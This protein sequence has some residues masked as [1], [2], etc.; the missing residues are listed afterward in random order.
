MRSLS[1]VVALPIAL[2]ASGALAADEPVNGGMYSTYTAKSDSIG[3]DR[4]FDTSPADN[5]DEVVKQLTRAI[6]R[7]AR[8]RVRRIHPG[9]LPHPARRA[10]ELRVRHA[11][12]D[13]RVVQDR[14]WH[15][16]RRLAQAGD[17]SV[18]PLHSAA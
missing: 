11:L 10:G 9:D 3:H 15:L 12:R 6:D 13:P 5:L 7:L 17:E 2:A 14:R 16:P 4:A 18:P 1:C 8:Y